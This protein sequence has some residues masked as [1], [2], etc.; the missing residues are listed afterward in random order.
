MSYKI[1]GI[2]LPRT[3]TTSLTK[4]LTSKGFRCKH[5]SV[6]LIENI[7]SDIYSHYDVFTDAPIPLIFP[8]LIKKFPNARFIQTIRNKE[9]W[10]ESMQWMLI[11]GRH[12]WNWSKEID[13]YHNRLFGSKYF[14][15]KLFSELWER[16]NQWIKN[17]FINNRSNLFTIDISEK[18][19]MSKLELFLKLPLS[20]QPFPKTNSRN[21]LDKKH[22]IPIENIKP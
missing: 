10:L 15:K 12:L 22:S 18:E 2:G 4:A 7:N 6:E 19:S 1:F 8:S 9:S 14:D 13:S 3:G 5:F 17:H 20:G 21:M 11:D 16:H